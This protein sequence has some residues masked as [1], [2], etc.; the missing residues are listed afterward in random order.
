M[1]RD[2]TYHYPPDL[3][4]LLIQTI[5]LLFSSKKGVLLFFRGAGVNSQEFNNL[6]KIVEKDKE[7]ISKYEIVRRLLADLNEKGE[8]SLRE[9]R[10]ILKRVTEFEDFSSAW[11]NDVLKAKGLVSEIRKVVNVKDSFTRMNI[12]RERESKKRQDEYEERANAIRKRKDELDGIKHELYSLFKMADIYKRGKALES[13]LNRLFK[14]NNILVRE[15]FTIVG[16]NSEGII[17]QIDG[18]VEIDGSLY[19]VEMKWWEKKLGTKEVSPHLVRIFNR[20]HAGGI[21]ISASGYTDPAIH[22]CKEALAQ[23]TV[24]LCELEEL[25]A[26]LEQQGNLKDFLKTKIKMAVTEKKPFVKWH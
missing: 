14:S 15:A 23:K 11:Q 4:E 3:F 26:L 1:Y 17:E 22:T 6:S 16:D 12:E 24:V 2:I 7:S 21:L 9:R 13:V 20:G 18:V 8:T 5:P 25:V 19:L 10:E